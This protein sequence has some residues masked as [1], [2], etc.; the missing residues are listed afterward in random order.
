MS[1]IRGRAN[2]RFLLTSFTCASLAVVGCQA[3]LADG[4]S[5]WPMF[6]GPRAMGVL[7][8]PATATSW[9]VEKG[10]NVLW[11]TPIPGLGHCSPI[12]WGDKVYL[13]TAISG[14][15]KSGLKPGLYGDIASV[16]DDTVHKWEIVCL[17]KKTGKIDWEKQL[18]TGVPKI[19]RHTKST[20]A[21]STMATDGKYLI[22]FF[23]SE[24][25]YCFD[26]SGKQLWKK[27][28]GVLDSGYYVVP[29]AQ[30]EYAAS[31][32][33]D[34][35]VV[36]VQ[37]DVQKGSFLAAFD[38]KTGQEKW[39]T[40]RD[41]VPTW[42]TPAIYHDGAKALLIVN[43]YKHMGAYDAATGK[44]IWRMSGGGD[45][46][47]PT[48]IVSN[49]LIFLQSAHGP[50]APIYA[51]KLSATGDITIKDD[52]TSSP[53]IAWATRRGG[54]YLQ[55]PLIIGDH[56]YTC[57][58]NGVLSCYEAKTGKQVYSERMGSGRTAFTSSP[59]AS[60]GMIYCASEDGDVYVVKAGPEFKIVATNP[61][62]EVCM[63]TPA[64]SDGIL[65]FRTQAN[66][67]AIKDKAGK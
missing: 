41:D 29:A 67:I 61:L 7:D 42:S 21:N 30:W 2:R 58:I 25:L 11:K 64:I 26:M 33:I 10:E 59:V 54:G 23:G 45:I 62:S 53:N 57:Q 6:H 55:T 32:I 37:C 20:H 36:Y 14:M 39:R 17:N 5:N 48:P 19:K 63:A 27:D 28:L 56:F 66:L 65:Y 34:E 47:V 16:P 52:E 44:E 4:D 18:L 15:E 12:I 38:A 46:P 3:A 60:N 51:V 31:P 22:A 8:G 43:G 24:G 35:G 50:K 13:S 40:D 49:G 9:N 1:R